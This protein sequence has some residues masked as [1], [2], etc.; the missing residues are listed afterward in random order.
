MKMDPEHGSKGLCQERAFVSGIQAANSL[1]ESTSA[2]CDTLLE[3]L[4][5][6]DDEVQFKLAAQA[7]N[8]VMKYLPRFW[9]R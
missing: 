9:V 5:T 1:L 8:A 4:P 7:N 2:D 6:R 3:V